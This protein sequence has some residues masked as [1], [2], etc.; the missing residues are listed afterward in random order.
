M[1]GIIMVWFFLVPAVP[2]TL[3]NFL[4]PLMIGARDLAFPKINLLSWY[5]FMAGGVCRALG[6]VCRRRRYRLDILH[7]AL[8][9]LCA[10]PCRRWSAAGVFIS[11]FSSIATG[12]NFIVTIHR[13]RAPGMTWYRMPVFCGRSTRPASSWCWRRRCWRSLCCCWRSSASSMSACSIPQLGGDPLLFQHLFWF[14]SH[15][16]V[17]IMILPGFGVVSEI[18]PAFSRKEMFGYKFV[19]WSSV[20]IAV[21]G[22]FVW[23]HHM[24]VAGQSA[25]CQ[26]RVLVAELLRRRAVGD[27]GV[28]LARHAAQRLH[29]LRC[30]DALCA[31]LH[32][33][34]HDGRPDRACFSPRWPRTSICTTRI[35][36]SR[37]STTSWWAAWYPPT[38]PG[39]TTGGRRSPAACIPR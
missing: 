4:V 16:A 17:Y 38:S 22:F 10:G 7:P 24:F 13:L 39:C 21:I 1:H 27:Q 25:V 12:L 20:S 32:R 8:H 2:V 14:Y 33:S 29:P 11:G 18:I 28:Q 34:V 19:V 26:R 15:P 3:G 30:A 36:S 9:E 23:G 35:S 5:L 37:I 31:R 6:H